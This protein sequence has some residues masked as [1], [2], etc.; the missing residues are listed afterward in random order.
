[1]RRASSTLAAI[2]GAFV[3]G[4]V[5]AV[6]SWDLALSAFADD[7]EN[8][9]FDLDARLAPT[10]HIAL[11]AGIGRSETDGRFTQFRGDA[12]RAAVELRNERFSGRLGYSEWRDSN[13]Y[14]SR[15]PQLA[16]AARVGDVELSLLAERRD[17]DIGYTVQLLLRDLERVFS[18]DGTGYGA[19]LAWTGTTWS[20]Y[21]RA[22]T[23]EYDESLDELI[24]LAQ[25]P[26]LR[27][28]PRIS[29]LVGSVLVL[30]QGALDWQAGAGV[31]RT[32]A[33]S[34]LSVDALA[35]RDAVEGADGRSISLTYAWSATR[36]LDLEL[37]GGLND[38]DGFDQSVFG[39]IAVVLHD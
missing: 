28:L 33:R 14:E 11:S 7:A 9:S 39:G 23:Y 26:D 1:M 15:T 25:R 2:L 22:L 8:T 21:G 18:F 5:S 27:F 3:A 36:R 32:F 31:Q 35:V 16:L 6:E 29:S 12:W 17:I 20:A 19:G 24:A 10:E 13:R 30:S 4:P 38:T 34:A 37:T